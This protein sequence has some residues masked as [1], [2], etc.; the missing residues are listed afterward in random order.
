M[1]KKIFKKQKK[2]NSDNK[3]VLVAALLIHAAKIDEN[4]TNKEKEI[5]KSELNGVEIFPNV[6]RCPF[7]G[8]VEDL[9]RF[10]DGIWWIQDAASQ[11]PCTILLTKI[12]P[13]FKIKFGFLEE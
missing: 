3:N 6:L 2:E 13:F 9:P 12:N 11:I 1:F 7:N 4:Y 8:N 10:K 5:I